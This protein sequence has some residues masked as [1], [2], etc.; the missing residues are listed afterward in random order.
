MNPPVVVDPALQRAALELSF[1][2]D[3]LEGG[4]M[5]V[6][7]LQLWA[8]IVVPVPEDPE[9][10]EARLATRALA[11]ALGL[12][13]ERFRSSDAD[14]VLETVLRMLDDASQRCSFR[15]GAPAELAAI[16]DAGK[17]RQRVGEATA[18]RIEE[19]LAGGR[20]HGAA[21]VAC[22]G[23]SAVSKRMVDDA[24]QVA[25]AQRRSKTEA[26]RS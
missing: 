23:Y 6:A 15:G 19:T 22:V 21:E 18:S 5:A 3:F 20:N 1:A 16:L 8:G 9:E 13:R 24:R 4:A 12:A 11:I 7:A 17:I 10:T 14:R 2:G 26:E 25:A